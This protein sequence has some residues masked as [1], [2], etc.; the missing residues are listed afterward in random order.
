MFGFN[1]NT[2]EE[3]IER[4]RLPKPISDNAFLEIF[5]K[6]SFKLNAYCMLKV[7]DKKHTEDIIQEIWLEF[8]SSVNQGKNIKNIQSYLMGIA[9]NLLY[10]YLKTQTRINQM[11]INKDGIHLDGFSINYNLQE[12]LEN[13]NLLSIVKLAASSLDE[14]YRDIYILKKFEE[15]TFIEIAQLTGESIQNIKRIYSKA[16][17][18]MEK[19]LRPYFDEMKK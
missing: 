7:F 14:P 2:D 12:C 8:V 19:L 1:T 6:Y 18:M 10:D 15:L 13:A 11:F 5:Q 17:I 16:S 4:M 9:C 3:L